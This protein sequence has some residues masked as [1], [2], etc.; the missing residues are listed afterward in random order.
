MFALYPRYEIQKDKT[1]ELARACEKTL[2][3]RFANRTKFAGHGI[4]GWADSWAA[5]CHARLGNPDKIMEHLYK[6]MSICSPSF[7]HIS[8]VMQIDGNM[9]GAAAI[10]EMLLSCDEERI[11][12]LPALPDMIRNG[13]FK[14]LRARGGF[15]VDLE[16][17]EGKIVSAT[18]TSLAGNECVIKAPGLAG[19]NAEFSTAGEYIKFNTV[20]GESYKLQF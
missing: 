2:E 1:P 4:V 5:A 20:K 13:S 7:L 15:S 11:M 19:V 8:Y 6:V 3:I 17:R 14:G 10:S 16:W 9:A 12:L 18:V